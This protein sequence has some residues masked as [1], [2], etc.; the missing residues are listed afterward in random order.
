MEGLVA[1]NNHNDDAIAALCAGLKTHDGHRARE[2]LAANVFA[3][4]IPTAPI[5]S[6]VLAHA[7]NFYLDADRK[8]ERDAIVSLCTLGNHYEKILPYI[9]EALREYSTY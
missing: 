1:L 4:Y 8:A 9:Y 3:E 5:F 2:G 6:K 7:V